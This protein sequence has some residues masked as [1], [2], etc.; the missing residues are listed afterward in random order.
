MLSCS[1]SLDAYIICVFMK[2]ESFVFLYN[3]LKLIGISADRFK[4]FENNS[5]FCEKDILGKNIRNIIN[6]NIF[7][8]ITLLIVIFILLC[9]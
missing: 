4:F 1:P 2:V 7:L 8:I 5:S 9:L 6:K 3:S